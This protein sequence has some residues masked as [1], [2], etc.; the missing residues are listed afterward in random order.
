M[1][2]TARPGA[3]RDL[4]MA[5]VIL[6]ILGDAVNNVGVV[7][8]GVTIWQSDAPERHY[9]DPAISAMVGMVI[10]GSCIPLSIM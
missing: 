1:Q 5:G 4:G 2:K 9:A 10:I 7:V 3:H 8:V 6:H